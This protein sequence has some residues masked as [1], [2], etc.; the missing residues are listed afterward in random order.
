MEVD[1]YQEQPNDGTAGSKEQNPF[2][3][4]IDQ[5]EGNGENADAAKPKRK[6]M[7]AMRSDDLVDGEHGLNSLYKDFVIDGPSRINLI[8]KKG[9]ELRDLHKIMQVYRNWHFQLQ[10]KLEFKY[11]IQRLQKLGNDKTTKN[12]M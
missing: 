9:T 3:A 10:P 4:E 1:E 12:H 7:T 2:M 11:F 6:G 5:V 8:G